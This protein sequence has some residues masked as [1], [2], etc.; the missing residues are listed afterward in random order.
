MPDSAGRVVTR[1]DRTGGSGRAADV[2]AALTA[3]LDDATRRRY[4]IGSDA[5]DAVAERADAAAQA[6][7]GHNSIWRFGLTGW[8]DVGVQ[9]VKQVGEDRVTSVAGGV[10]FFALLAL[11]PALTALVSIYGLVSDPAAIG[12]HLGMIQRLLPEG[13][14]DIIEGQIAAITSAPG[15]ALSLAGVMALF[16]AIYSA[17]GGTKALIEA[18][19][20]AFF[21]RENRGFVALNLMAVGLTLGAIVLVISMIGVIAVIP[22]LLAWLPMAEATAWLVE[23]LRWPAMLAVLLLALAALYRFAPNRPQNPFQ[24]Y[25]P[26]ALFAAIGLVAGSMLFSWYAANFANYNKTYGT[27]GAVIGL[28]MWM[29]I[30]AMVVMVGAE[31]N[32]EIE[33]RLRRDNGLPRLEDGRKPEDAA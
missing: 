14:Y 13:A 2:V 32:A 12:R 19:N 4:G 8:K 17:T 10:T 7:G 25:W 30:S 28:M 18:M 31:L 16:M 33:Q 9:T 24:R 1:S 21:Q 23:W 22:A 3:P 5:T 15:T 26:G 20:V 27:L 29:W 11:F 6:P